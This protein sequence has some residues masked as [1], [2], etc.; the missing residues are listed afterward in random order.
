MMKILIWILCTTLVS[1]SMLQRLNYGVIFNQ[2]TSLQLDMES[3]IH[4]F[5]I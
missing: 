1:G 2:E 3:W 4:T 5:E